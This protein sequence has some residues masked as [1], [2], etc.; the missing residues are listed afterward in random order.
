MPTYTIQVGLDVTVGVDGGFFTAQ[1]V[2]A[3]NDGD[4]A[5]N[6]TGEVGR[7]DTRGRLRFHFGNKKSKLMSG[8]GRIKW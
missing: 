7:G 4:I 5:A 8:S 1:L 6:I 2:D 3:A